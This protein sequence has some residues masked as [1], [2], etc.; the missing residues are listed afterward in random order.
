MPKWHNWKEQTEP[1][2]SLKTHLLLVAFQLA[3]TAHGWKGDQSEKRLIDP[4]G[5]IL[6]H[7]LDLKASCTSTS[8]FPPPVTLH[9]S[10]LFR[11]RDVYNSLFF[12][13]R[14][15]MFIYFW[16]W[17]CGGAWCARSMQLSTSVAKPFSGSEIP[18]QTIMEK[19]SLWA[20]GK[21]ASGD[22]VSFFPKAHEK[23]TAS[24]K[25]RP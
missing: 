14:F 17:A 9:T 18:E 12:I 16:K 22:L 25:C 4:T 2:S 21:V 11:A 20:D 7:C 15:Y 23:Q 19:K 13:N 5:L 1:L 8:S 24:D 6:S 3:F 10:Q